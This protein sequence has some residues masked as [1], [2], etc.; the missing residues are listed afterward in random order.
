M[1]PH[2]DLNELV[3]EAGGGGQRGDEHIKATA[4]L[5]DWHK[6]A[7][8]TIG[9]ILDQE[10]LVMAEVGQSLAM[11]KLV[12]T[13]R[14]HWLTGYDYRNNIGGACCAPAVSD[15]IAFQKKDDA[16]R[17]HADRA[18]TW[19][20]RQIDSGNSCLSE[21]A[22]DEARRMINLLARV[23]SPPPRAPTQLNLF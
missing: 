17:F 8:N 21:R 15:R 20:R 1:L 10:D 7:T 9:V 5:A 3:A 13:G 23:I 18:R 16:I 19:F 2:I 4:F 6:I 14:G 12:Q 22:K 11:V